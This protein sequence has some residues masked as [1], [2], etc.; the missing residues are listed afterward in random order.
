MTPTVRWLIPQAVTCARLILGAY[1]AGAALDGRLY[2]AATLISLGAVTDGL[3]GLAAR[4]LRAVSA[5]GAL[6]DY[7]ADY[8]CYI[9]APWALARGLLDS[10]SGWWRDAILVIPLMTGAIRYARNGTVTME[11]TRGSEVPGLATVFFA[12]LGVAAVFLDAPTA[13]PRP[14]FS[15]VFVALQTTFALLMITTV[16]CPKITLIPGMSPIVLALIGL[17][18]FVATKAIALTMFVT[19]LVYPF[20]AR[21]YARSHQVH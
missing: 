15:L 7:F 3:D 10:E 11:A 5:F 20:A 4:R 9:V 14:M 16:S 13:V 21:L 6:F 18:P 17:M 1:A 8:L 12:F 19:G 2:A